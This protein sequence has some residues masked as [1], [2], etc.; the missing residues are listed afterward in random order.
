MWGG[1]R[2]LGWPGICLPV[3]GGWSGG[4]LC[5]ECF[6]GAGQAGE[7]CLIQSME[8]ARE[9]AEVGTGMQ[10][11]AFGGRGLVRGI[12]DVCGASL[13]APTECRGPRDI[14]WLSPVLKVARPSSG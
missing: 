8:A 1:G 4:V 13:P 2:P 6:P 5:W 7:R 14:N 9:P 12:A 11:S 3:W 10:N